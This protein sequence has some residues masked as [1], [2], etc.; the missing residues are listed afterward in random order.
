MEPVVAEV[1]VLERVG[2]QVVEI[3]AR[4]RAAA[5]RERHAGGAHVDE[6]LAPEVEGLAPVGP[7]HV[8]ER[9]ADVAPPPARDASH[10]RDARRRRRDLER[11]VHAQRSL[12]DGADEDGPGSETGA[13]FGFVE[14]LAEGDDVAGA[15][16]L[17]DA[18]AVNLGAGDCHE[19]VARHAV[20]EAVGAGEDHDAHLDEPARD[21]AEDGA[22]LLLVGER[23]EVLQVEADG[24]HAARRDRE[25]AVAV[26]RR[27]ED[28]RPHSAGLVRHAHCS[29][30]HVLVS[31]TRTG[32]PARN[33][34]MSSTNCSWKSRYESA[35]T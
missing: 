6:H 10:V 5:D 22:R 25:D 18:H 1:L 9:A 2:A 12:D 21:V 3:G 16:G 7:W 14:E 20:G 19:V 17:G 4:D 33:P 8:A 27:H 11:V 30:G 34:A 31:M 32:L 23:C 29:H 13:S 26:V 24:V 15:V 35:L 28:E